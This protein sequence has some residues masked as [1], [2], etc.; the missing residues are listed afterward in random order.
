MCSTA[1][2]RLLLCRGSAL[3]LGAVINRA[4]ANAAVM[5][6]IGNNFI[7]FLQSTKPK[8]SGYRSTFENRDRNLYRLL[9]RTLSKEIGLQEKELQNSAGS[10]EIDYGLLM[11][12]RKPM[13]LLRTLGSTPPRTAARTL[14]TPSENDPP[15]ITQ[16]ASSERFSASSFES[17]G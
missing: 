6:T 14:P 16:S 4:Q 15:R 7:Q 10:A 3:T 17:Y 13:V 11:T 1:C 9:S 12:T 8:Y 2:L 5:F